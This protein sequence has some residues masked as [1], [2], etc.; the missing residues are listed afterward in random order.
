[1]VAHPADH[2]R[3]NCSSGSYIRR[4]FSELTLWSFAVCGELNGQQ[5]IAKDSGKNP[6]WNDGLGG[7]RFK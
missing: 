2:G 7:G 5:A 4:R 1:L 6:G 3:R